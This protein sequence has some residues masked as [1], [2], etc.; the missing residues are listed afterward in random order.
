VHCLTSGWIDSL[1]SLYK[2]QFQKLTFVLDPT[3]TSGVSVNAIITQTINALI[4]WLDK[5]APSGSNKSSF[6]MMVTAQR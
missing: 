3:V 6:L 4:V 5:G 1:S 2:Q